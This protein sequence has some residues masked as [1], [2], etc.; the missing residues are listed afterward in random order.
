MIG[1]IPVVQQR[2]HVFQAL[3][4]LSSPKSNGSETLHEISNV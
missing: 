4:L 2:L 1:I 3:L